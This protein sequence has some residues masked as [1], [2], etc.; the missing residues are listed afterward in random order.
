MKNNNQSTAE[1]FGYKLIF[2][3]DF[4]NA[5]LDKSKWT[6]I[7]FAHTAVSEKRAKATYKI[8]DSCLHLIIDETT[9]IYTDDREMKVSSIQTFEKNLLH[10]GAGTVNVNNVEVFNGFSTQYGYFE[11][12][13]KLPNC[14]GGGHM[15]WWMVGTQDDADEDGKNS[16][17]TGEIDIVENLFDDIN[18]FRPSV[19]ALTDNNLKEFHTPIRLQQNCDEDFHIYAMN[20][21]KDKIDFIFDGEV[22]A[23]TEQSPAYP[24]GMFIGMY[25]NCGWSG[26]DNGVYPKC[27][28]VD[29]VRVY[30]PE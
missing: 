29:Y 3:E 18:L 4:D 11:M 26:E 27:L 13:A 17:Q 22:V 2:N 12:R 8:E 7:Y 24:M 23:S 21:E 6:D 14:R 19:H 5:V 1:K 9:P 30:K 15:A 16:V 20:W 25:T 10:P 28:L